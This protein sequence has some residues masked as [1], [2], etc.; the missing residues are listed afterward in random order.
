[1]ARTP[2]AALARALVLG[3]AV[4]AGGCATTPTA[5]N[6]AATV[7]AVTIPA[8]P[9]APEPGFDWR[10]LPLAPFGSRLQELHVPVH[11][12]LLFQDS[13]DGQGRAAL[14]ERECFAPDGP[15]RQFVGREVDSD[16]LCFHDGR[17]QRVEVTVSLP[18]GEAA[19]ELARYCDGWLAVAT[20]GGA[21]TPAHCSGAAAHGAAFDATLGD[22]AEDEMAPLVIVVQ[23]DSLSDTTP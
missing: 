9:R 2:Q 13:N 16:L 6:A 19:R 8:P 23:D 11:E 22:P 3:A 21:R 10:T 5:P 20:A 15:R 18:A 14:P 4:M 12:V 7:P 1:M 17:L